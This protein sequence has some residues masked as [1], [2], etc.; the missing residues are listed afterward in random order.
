MHNKAAGLRI[1]SQNVNQLLK[2]DS[3]WDGDRE[4]AREG[5]INMSQRGRDNARERKWWWWW[6]ELAKKWQ[7]VGTGFS[8]HFISCHSIPCFP[9]PF[10]S[11]MQSSM[12][13]RMMTWTCC[14]LNEHV[15]CLF[16]HI[17]LCVIIIKMPWPGGRLCKIFWCLKV[18]E[19]QEKEKKPELN[20]HL[21]REST[22][23]F[24]WPK[25]NVF[26]LF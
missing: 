17:S 1:I 21:I 18:T 14:V 15:C 9:I 2:E 19:R 10:C 25:Q 7:N 20:W 6:Q 26:N 13:V 22:K 11:F 4:R 8:F 23:G 3:K 24:R 16:L 12:S 5:T